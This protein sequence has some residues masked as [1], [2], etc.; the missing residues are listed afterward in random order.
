MDAITP[1]GAMIKPPQQ[2]NPLQTLSGILGL[3]Q[4]QLA[5]Q[6]G[7]QQLTTQTAEAQQAQQK[8]QQLT[9]LAQ[10]YKGLPDNPAYKNPDGTLNVQKATQD[11]TAIAGTYGG[12][13]INQVI[14]NLADAVGV[15]Q[16]IMQ[17]GD[18][19]RNSSADVF[20]GL[21]NTPGLTSGMIVR[22]LASQAK[23]YA[24]DPN[25][26]EILIHA[27]S[28]FPPGISNDEARAR[29]AA[30]AGSFNGKGTV[31]P[32]TMNLGGMVQ[33]GV[34][35]IAG[36]ETGAFSSAGPARTLTLPPQINNPPGGGPQELVGGAYGTAGTPPAP[37][38]GG[39]PPP[40]AADWQ[41]FAQYQNNLNQRVRVATDAQPIISET[42]E[43]LK[44]IRN[45]AGASQRA[46]IAKT[47]Q[48]LGAPTPLVDAVD[49]GDLGK[50]QAAEKFLFQT[51]LMGLRQAMQG[52]PARVAEFNEAN[53]V[54]PN[55]DTDPRA[56]QMLLNFISARAQR[57]Y[58]EQQALIKARTDGTF[59]PVTWEGEYQQ[60]LRA[61][62]VPG[63]PAGQIPKL[64]GQSSQ[65]T[66]GPKEGETAKSKS[67]KPIIFRDG[68][69]YYE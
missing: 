16:K 2:I 3:K 5:L 22:E 67:G 9:A 66:N 32:S 8:N 18:K 20:T 53:K 36:P 29:V 4:Q 28:R 52:D 58:A 35:T 13:A 15:K 57:D 55:I 26:Q 59:N 1:V 45:K 34:T 65:S 38:M 31:A 46:A 47:L 11:A 48:S 64:S 23:L 61:G 41:N 10:F 44:A 19:E 14:G 60:Q 50:T 27:A 21:A 25:M 7:Q 49:Q 68:H 63:T 40:S 56:K 43:A 6:T 51:T 12:P 17:L 37:G 24:G 69:W 42:E 54:F 33:P 39:G 30:L 62:K